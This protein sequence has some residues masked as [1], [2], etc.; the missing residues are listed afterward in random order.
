MAIFRGFTTIIGSTDSWSI[1]VRMVVVDKA[2]VLLVTTTSATIIV[3]L[4]ARIML[5]GGTVLRL[6]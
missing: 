2:D 6:V 3:I 4:Y 5:Q 1:P